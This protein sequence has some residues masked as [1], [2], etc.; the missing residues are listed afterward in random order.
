[1]ESYKN[2]FSNNEIT[3]SYEPCKCIHAE[4][5]ARELSEVFR[6]SILP[7]INLEGTE[8]KRIIKQIKRCPSGALSYRENI[9]KHAS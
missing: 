9:N 1:M 5:C 4:K 3:V 6:T 2:E 7:W 8:T